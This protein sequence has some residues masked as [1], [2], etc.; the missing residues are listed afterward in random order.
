M[1]E[2]V[3]SEVDKAGIRT[4]TLNRPKSLNAM[5][6][7]LIEEVAQAFME[8]DADERTKVIIFTGAGRAFCAGD[9]LNEHV[10]PENEEA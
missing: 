6:R 4:I 1:Y 10:A 2:T 3:L 9:D 7:K 5:N 8:A